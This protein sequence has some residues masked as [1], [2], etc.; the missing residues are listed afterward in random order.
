M[1]ET[2]LREK[3]IEQPVANYFRNHGWKYRKQAGQGDRGKTDK[4][5]TSSPGRI[6]FVEF[7]RSGKKPTELQQLEIDNWLDS[8]FLA[9]SIDNIED[10]E[11]LCDYLSE[12]FDWDQH[13]SDPVGSAQCFESAFLEYAEEREEDEWEY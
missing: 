13:A 6:I 7:K 10:G 9:I 4:F 3:Q 5:F 12:L 2:D 1:T 11:F 8:G